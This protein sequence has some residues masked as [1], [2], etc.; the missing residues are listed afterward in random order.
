MLNS[1]SIH[2]HKPGYFAPATSEPSSEINDV[3]VK[4]GERLGA[5]GASG[6]DGL[7]KFILYNDLHPDRS[8]RMFQD[9]PKP[10]FDEAMRLLEDDMI[11]YQARML[12]HAAVI[13]GVTAFAEGLTEDLSQCSS[14]PLSRRQVSILS[15]F[16][17]N[18]TRINTILQQ[19]LPS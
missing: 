14:I 12:D 16:A 17:K 5:S 1:Q 19:R 13:Y 8:R 4:I 18:I 10:L 2:G 15:P 11:L 6:Q 7:Q 3:I 9:I